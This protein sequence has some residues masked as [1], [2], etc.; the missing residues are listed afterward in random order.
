MIRAYITSAV[1][2]ALLLGLATAALAVTGEFGNRC[3]MSLV[4][5]KDTPTDCSISELYGGKTYCFGDQAAHDLFM[6]SPAENL[7]KAQKNYSTMFPT[8]AQEK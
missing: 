7:A 2:G 8:K 3:A 5:G 6:K 1:A 4:N